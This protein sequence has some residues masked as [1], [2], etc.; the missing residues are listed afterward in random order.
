[1]HR[2]PVEVASIYDV[3]AH[4]LEL[5]GN[6]VRVI[7]AVVE[8]WRR[9]VCAVANHERDT[10]FGSARLGEEADSEHETKRQAS[11]RYVHIQTPDAGRIF[12]K[13]HDFNV[14]SSSCGRE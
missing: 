10:R 14:Q 1:M 7:S 6:I 5:L 3:K 11:D 4:P 9:P 12:E 2:R 13:R 8:F